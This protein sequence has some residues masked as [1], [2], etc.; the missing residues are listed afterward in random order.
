[1]QLSNTTIEFGKEARSNLM[2]GVRVLAD[3][4]CATLGPNGRNVVI[5]KEG[6]L[7]PFSTKDG[8]TVAKSVKLKDPA[9]E[10]GVQLIRQAADKTAQDAGDGTTTSTLLAYEMINNGLEH[11]DK[12]ENA[13]KI[14]REIDEAVD[15]IVDT[16]KIEASQDISNPDQVKQ[17]ATISGN[18]DEEIGTII[19]T[20]IQKVGQE[21]AVHIETSNT[22]ET[23]LETVEGMQIDRGYKS[24]YMVTHNDT[25]TCTLEDP[26]ILIADKRF[27]TVKELLPLLE[28]LGAQNKSLLIVAEDIEGEALATLI[29]NKMRGTL[30]VAAVKAPDFGDRRKL[31][32]EDIATV[33][34]GQVFSS[35]KGMKIEKFSWDWFGRARLVT[36]SKDKTTIIDGRGLEDEINN[37]VTSI[38]KQI[39]DSTSPFE[40]EKLQERLAKMSGGV[41]IVHVGGRTET[42]MNEKKDRVDD[43]LQATKAA[44]DEGIV[45]GGGAALLYTIFELKDKLSLTT[46]GKIVSKACS[47]PFSRILS[48]AGYEHSEI[49]KIIDNIYSKNDPSIGYNLDKSNISDMIKDGIIDPTLVTRS[50]LENAASI[51]GTVLLTECAIVEDADDKAKKEENMMNMM[52]QMQ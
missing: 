44:I 14:K 40:V 21:G 37:R 4:V 1:M 3:A 9:Q 36:I 10:L 35:D 15:M 48:N 38:Q 6:E 31:L 33:T 20:A 5:S 42:E 47:Q 41:A 8:V 39:D 12:G 22:G 7:N 30:K 29:V 46:G 16:L 34:G 50:A 43:S 27:N 17:V 32:L 11:L 52:S 19:S 2:K 18:N 51:A 26:Y 23:Y 49:N 24:H 45:A 13:T 25:M 28:G